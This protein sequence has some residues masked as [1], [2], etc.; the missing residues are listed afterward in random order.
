MIRKTGSLFLAVLLGT[1]AGGF[2]WSF[3]L[4]MNAGIALFWEILPGHIGVRFYPLLV[5]GL[6]GIA[7][8]LCQ[9]KFGAYP[10]ELEK[11]IAA[12][13]TTRRYEYK[14]VPAITVTAL[15]PIVFGGSIGPEAGLSGAVAGFCTWIG[16]RLL[17]AAKVT[18]KRILYGAAAL[19]GLGAY[20]LLTKY[21]GG[22]IVFSRF[23]AEA[24]GQRELM[25]FVPFVLLGI[26]MGYFYHAIGQLISL[27]MRPLSRLPVLRAVI[28]GAALGICGIFL[29]YT[30][31]SGEAEIGD[32]MATWTT[33]SALLLFR[34]GVY[35]IAMTNLCIRSGW[36]GGH[37]FP[38]IFSGVCV[39]YGMAVVS[40]AGGVFSVAVVTAAFC[41]AVMRQPITVIIVLAL[42]FHIQSVPFLCAAAFIGARMPVP[43]ALITQQRR[44]NEC[45]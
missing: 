18:S 16:D 23:N 27:S 34:S 29:P 1:A 9:K 35:K 13:K 11:V 2:V 45:H 28:G 33:M 5:C 14:N 30:L 8:G 43:K 37:I 41:G 21:S 20:I 32:V 19:G 7:V 24:F 17:S 3:V 22:G 15:L 38:L 36:K 42:F 4:I 40:G 10:E 31:L 12:V 39:G 25:W 26:A 6:G 44:E